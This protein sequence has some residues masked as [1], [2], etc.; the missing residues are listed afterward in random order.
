[1]QAAFSLSLE[2]FDIPPPRYLGM[3]VRDDGLVGESPPH[4]A[5]H[6]TSRSSETRIEALTAYPRWKRYG[7]A[8]A[9]SSPSR[10]RALTATTMY[11]LPSCMYVIGAPD[12]PASSSVCHST[13]PVALS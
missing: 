13:R 11:C 1:M 4:A 2:A 12:V 7:R 10:P 9:T 6:P 8:K 3:G 5:A